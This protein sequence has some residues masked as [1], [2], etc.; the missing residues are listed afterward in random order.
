MKRKDVGEAVIERLDYPNKGR[1][2]VTEAD[3]NVVKG[4]VKNT[5]PGQKLK[6]RVYKKHGGRVEANAIEILEHSPLE[7]EEP[8]CAIFG[9]CGGCLYQRIPY[10]KQLA[11]K[12]DMVKRL[13]EP[14]LN[15][16]SVYDGI[17][18]SPQK[19][20]FRN[21]VEFSFG[22]EYKGGPLTLGLHRKATRYTVLNADTC[23]NVHPDLR[24]I[25]VAMREFCVEQDLPMYNK[26]IHEGYLRFLLLRRSETTGEILLCVAHSTQM[27]YDWSK[28]VPA[29]QALPLEGK[30]VGIWE[31]DDDSYG[32]A[33]KPENLRCVWGQ[34]YFTEKLLGLSFKVT[35][36]SFFQT[37]TK[38]A[39]V[40]YDLV[41]QYVKTSFQDD[42]RLNGEDADRDSISHTNGFGQNVDSQTG[43]KRDAHNE[44]KPVLYDLYCGTGTI[45]QI[46][47]PVASHVYGI[48]IIPEA[49]E[50]AKENAKL[51]GIDNCTFYAGDVMEKLDELEEKPDYLIL[52]PPRE[53]IR[54]KTLR[55]LMDYEVDHIVYVSCKASSFVQ[56]MTVMKTYGW[57][58]ERY[59]LV[60]MFPNASSIEMVCLLYNRNAK[61][62][63]Y[64]DVSLNMEDYKIKDDGKDWK[65]SKDDG[66][67]EGK[68]AGD[69]DKA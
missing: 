6:F 65:K 66:W 43:L 10:K 61:P 51:N 63:S 60:D 47:S 62:D 49:V 36:F 30:I 37:N 58:I 50:A 69:K 22:N 18:G 9:D 17:E 59:A 40:L 2:T 52:D 28:V 20:G 27:I 21:K 32:D 54:P 12:E 42:E 64:I 13:L 38:G 41:R 1:F 11:M 7:T 55:Q 4:T 53:G 39:E 24:K 31:T 19:T 33:L 57:K 67:A 15:S 68:K 48:E 34:N 3:G 23:T 8:S 14:V 29:L 16:D 44:K 56:D 5:I 35:L 46:V 26:V 25:L 45:A